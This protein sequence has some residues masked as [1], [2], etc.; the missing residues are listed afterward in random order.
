[1][2]RRGALIV[3][4]GPSGVGKDSVLKA[5]MPGRRDIMLSISA[6]TRPPRVNEIDGEHYHFISQ[7]A[8]KDMIAKDEML[9]YAEY[10]GN[11]YG[12]PRQWVEENLR[13]GMHVILEIELVGALKIRALMPEAVFV[14][15]MP[16]SLSTLRDRLIGRGTE[17]PSSISAR[18]EAAKKEI[19]QASAYDYIIVNHTLPDSCEKL[20]AIIGAAAQRA[21]HL[22][23]IIQEVTKDA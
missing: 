2:T 12:T 20:S 10:A 4:S 19:L 18:M 6:T 16:P 3:V 22:K 14:F 11:Y 5:F 7:D 21:S 15:L 1:M 23:D 13:R 8:F 17:T 9:E